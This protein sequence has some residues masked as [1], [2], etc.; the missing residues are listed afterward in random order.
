MQDEQ[1]GMIVKVFGS[2][3]EFALLIFS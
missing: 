3:D 2:S 1:M